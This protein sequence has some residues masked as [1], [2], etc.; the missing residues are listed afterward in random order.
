MKYV[1]IVTMK[2]HFGVVLLM[3]ETS[4]K[5]TKKQLIWPKYKIHCLLIKSSTWQ[6]Q[7]MTNTQYIISIQDYLRF[8]NEDIRLSEVQHIHV[9]L[10]YIVL[11]VFIFMYSLV[12][13]FCLLILYMYLQYYIAIE[14]FAPS[15]PINK[16]T[17]QLT[18]RYDMCQ[19]CL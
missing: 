4:T 1:S 14:P 17:I 2:C 11:Y 12:H 15:P 6:R 3:K 13:M 8:N 9:S 7:P 19:L 16:C 10:C 5:Q 18:K